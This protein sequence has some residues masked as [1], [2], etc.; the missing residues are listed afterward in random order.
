MG[1]FQTLDCHRVAVVN[2]LMDDLEPSLRVNRVLIQC[3]LADRFRLTLLEFSSLDP[4]SALVV[5]LVNNDLRRRWRWRT[6][7]DLLRIS[8]EPIWSRKVRGFRKLN[9]RL[10]VVLR[11]DY[12]NTRRQRLELGL[13]QSHQSRDL[14]VLVTG[15]ESHSD[16]EAVAASPG[17]W[18]YLG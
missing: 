4:L 10:I 11:G 14:R 13:L 6:G 5:H 15:R 2:L 8:P 17:P 16:L 12:R 1:G 9:Q 18:V 7:R 3:S